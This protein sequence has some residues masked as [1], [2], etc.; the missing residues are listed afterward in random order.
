M[1]SEESGGSPDGISVE[2]EP[3]PEH[4][5]ERPSRRRPRLLAGLTP[6]GIILP[7]AILALLIY[8]FSSGTLSRSG[9]GL[10]QITSPAPPSATLAPP[11][12]SP[13]PATGPAQADRSAQDLQEQLEQAQALVERS[14]FED[15]LAI[16]ED[17]ARY[18]PDD[19]RPQIGWAWALILDGQ[20][21]QAVAHAYRSVE[22]DPT[23]AQTMAVL[24]RAYADIGDKDRAL[25][26]AQN[27]V[28]LDPQS[29]LAHVVLAQANWLNAL[30]QAAVDEAEQALALD[31]N[32]AEAH[33]IRGWLY[34]T[35]D[36]DL[37]QAR[38]ELQRAA[39]L[40]PR[41]W[42]RHYEQGLILA[43][44]EEYQQAL[45]VLTEALDLRPR[46]S[47]YTALGNV[48][49]HL[50]QL[51]PA[52]AALLEALAT[53][54]RLADTLG[55]LAIVDAEESRCADARLYWEQALSREPDHP[56]A[57]QARDLCSQT[58]VEPGLTPTSP[59][60]QE[61]TQTPAPLG[62][63]IAFPVWNLETG[64]YD[65]YV[66]NADG[67]ERQLVVREM[68]QPAFRPDGQWLAVNGE[69]RDHMNL[70]VVKPDGTGL[71]EIS[72]YIEDSLPSW[73][74]TG[75]AL[76]FS[77]TRHEDR[78]P[79][80]YILDQVPFTGEQQSGRILNSDLYELLGEGP[81]W[82]LD[83]EIIYQ[84]CDYTATPAQ[85]GLY[86]IPAAPG[87]Q[88][89]RQ[90]TSHP[91]DSAP[92]VS[93]DRIAFMSNRDGNW[94]LYLVNS[95]GSGLVRLTRTPANDG[96]PTW[97]PDGAH[98]AFA[99]DRGGRWA[100]WAIRPDGSDLRKLFDLGEGGL[101]S[102]WQRERISWGP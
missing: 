50:G 99:S 24:A 22:L 86:T 47:I 61:P 21:D 80:L 57:L 45:A 102:D 35:V 41:L 94:D 44:S 71:K 62:G 95:D 9:S 31:K 58:A 69:L 64:Q 48:Y 49:Y 91:E 40:Q 83:D 68:H 51:A 87:P 82:T 32:S 16:Y 74:P 42:L 36:D 84:G 88:V 2:S 12:P 60:P 11:N 90:L 23:S 18:L 14:R 101:A 27:A 67:S 15:A 13:T 72:Q 98:I 4:D 85:C 81:A 100:I 5:D 6:T 65:T 28:Q 43:D 33:R 93:G 37:E 8:L 76:A 52:R 55:L 92:A 63:R 1:K 89:P 79:R 19:P 46:P 78:N 25:G 38:S 26:M 30:D 77:S 56:L 66:T 29:A 39:E 73:S 3:N 7:L 53:G 96:L 54:A 34:A 20:P 70:F 97:A 10:E 75:E 17:L 59:V